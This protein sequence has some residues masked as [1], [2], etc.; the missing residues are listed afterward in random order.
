MVLSSLAPVPRVVLE[1]KGLLFIDKP[2]GLSFHS[3][4]EDAPGVMPLLRS[5]PE[6]SSNRLYPVHRLDRV[7]SGL[8][9]VAKSADAATA[10]GQLL[11]ERSIHKYYTAISGRKPAKKQGKVSG[12]MTR[13]RRAQW[14]LLRSK[15]NPA[16]TTFISQRLDHHSELDGDG[17]NVG[18][19]SS[20]DD[21]WSA[22]GR[23]AC[24]LKPLTGRT[25][26]LRVALKALGSPIL[27]D[28]MYAAAA[29]AKREERCYLHATALRVPAGCPALSEGGEAIEVVCRPS[30]GSGWHTPAFERAWS[31]WFPPASAEHG[32]WR[33]TWFEGTPVAS[34][35]DERWS[36]G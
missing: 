20:A 3:E 25:H 8:L 11:R 28:P 6:L 30:T 21:G 9:M 19:A 33:A 23:V 10:V 24:V 1:T 31:G 15:D 2:A 4:G 17:A 26:Q 5:M 34:R 13:S 22:G 36:G 12:D 16:V 29:E 27:G 14:M 7:T 32:E 35:L 18:G